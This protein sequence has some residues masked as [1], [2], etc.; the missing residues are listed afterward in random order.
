MQQELQQNS[1]NHHQQNPQG[2]QQNPQWED[3]QGGR[4]RGGRGNPRGRGTRRRNTKFYCWTHISC[5]HT[6][7]F[8]NYPAEG[9]QIEA[10]FAN[11]MG[12]STRYCEPITPK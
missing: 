8:C 5:A 10:T 1:Y 2:P 11:K 9:H 4:G 3:G 7:K 6:S 12:G